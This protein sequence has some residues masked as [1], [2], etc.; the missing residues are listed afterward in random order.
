MTDKVLQWHPGFCAALQIELQEEFGKAKD[1]LPSEE[2]C[3]SRWSAEISGR[4]RKQHQ[5]R[6]DRR[7]DK[8]TDGFRIGTEIRTD[9]SQRSTEIRHYN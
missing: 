5:C 2:C 6:K 1:F 7:N 9:S 8:E 3:G 4:D